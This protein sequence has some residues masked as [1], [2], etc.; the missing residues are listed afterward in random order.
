MAKLR[1][2]AENP[3]PPRGDESNQ[4]R[5]LRDYL[6]RLKDELEYL[7]THL[8]EDNLDGDLAGVIDGLPGSFGALQS[9]ADALQNQVD[10]LDAEKQDVLTFDNA[11]TSGSDNPVKSGGVYTALSG[12]QNT[13]TFD[14]APT[15]G[16]NN[17]V[18][19]GG[20]YTALAGKQ[21]TLTIDPSP[22]P[23]SPNPVA[24]GGVSAELINMWAAINEKELRYFYRQTVF[25][26]ANAEIFRITNPAITA[27]TVVLELSF[28]APEYIRSDVTWTSYAGYIS[29]AGTCTA[30]TTAN[31]TLGNKA[32]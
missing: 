29:F 25:P 11:P 14:N 8:G 20:I 5:E 28:A 3:P 2:L 4:L 10:A 26:A 7:L 17:P 23:D 13:L 1:V 22:T 9:R 27:D 18:K 12:K 6:T 16:S 32:N 21:N 19:S 30:G 31:V 24:S 15:S